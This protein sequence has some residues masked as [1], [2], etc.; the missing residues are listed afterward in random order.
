MK[1]VLLTGAVVAAWVAL[2]AAG[3]IWLTRFLV[4]LP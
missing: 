3:S 1:R 4:G 2:M